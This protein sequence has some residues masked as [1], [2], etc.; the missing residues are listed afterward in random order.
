MSLEKKILIIFSTLL[1]LFNLVGCSSETQEGKEGEIK[2]YT[3]IYPLYDF[4]KKVGGDKIQVELLVPPGA[5][6]HG[7][8][9]SA[10]KVAEIEEGNLFLY[11]GLEMDPWAEKLSKSLEGTS[12][13]TLALGEIQGIEPI[14]FKEDHDHEEEEEHGI[15]DPHIW[16]DPMNAKGMAETI[17]NELVKIDGENKDYYEERFITFKDNLEKLD[18]EYRESLSQGQKKEFVVAHAAFG[19]LARRYDLKQIS[20]SGLAPQAEPSPS[21]LVELTKVVEKYNIN[22]IFFEN[23]SSPKLSEVLASETGTK[24]EVLNPIGGLTQEEMDKGQEYISI[25]RENLEK[26]EEALK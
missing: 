14:L 13:H 3:S 8:E 2:V 26:L 12:V 1:L 19:Y 11:N 18:K 10:K 16:L 6:P 4:T 15:Y 7:F 5:E 21:K 24:T 23:L 25:M 20:I 9:P 17:K 22:T